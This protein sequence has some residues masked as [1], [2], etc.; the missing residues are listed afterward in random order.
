[1]IQFS[2]NLAFLSVSV[3]LEKKKKKKACY[4]CV[5]LLHVSRLLLLSTTIEK[6]L[7][8]LLT[9]VMFILLKNAIKFTALTIN[10]WHLI[11]FKT[12]IT[13]SNGFMTL[14]FQDHHMY[15]WVNV[16]KN[17]S[18]IKMKFSVPVLHAELLGSIKKRK[19]HQ[20]S[21]LYL[22]FLQT[23]HRTRSKTAREVISQIL[24]PT[25]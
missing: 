11:N 19:T 10:L 12:C 13:V 16:K 5:K 14:N 24:K 1:M 17:Q 9:K 22:L 8:A 23:H 20:S 6:P 2:L 15:L 25:E 7:Q 4:Q 3:D 18:I 21:N